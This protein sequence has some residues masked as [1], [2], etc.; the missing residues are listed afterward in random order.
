M[1][2]HGQPGWSESL[3]HLFQRLQCTGWA[4]RLVWQGQ[5][6]P[7]RPTRQTLCNCLRSGLRNHVQVLTR[8]LIPQYQQNHCN[9]KTNLISSV[10]WLPTIICSV[11]SI[12][13]IKILEPSC[14]FL[15]SLYFQVFLFSYITWT[16]PY[17]IT[18][19][20][21]SV[22]KT[23]AQMFSILGSNYWP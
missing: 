7:L 20:S 6:S 16:E 18:G 9:F 11:P 13:T 1:S 21:P 2:E 12:L 14:N 23:R 19:K 10:H 4:P 5:L 15:S 22:S 8:S 3:R 17:C